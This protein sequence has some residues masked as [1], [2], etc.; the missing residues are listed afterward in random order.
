MTAP[1]TPE[2]PRRLPLNAFLLTEGHHE[3]AWRLPESDP[4]RGLDVG[5][6]IELAR[7]AER[8]K[9]D[10]IFF[11][12]GPALGKDPGRRPSAGFE[13]ITLLSAIAVATERIGLAGSHH[14]TDIARR[15]AEAAAG[16]EETA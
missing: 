13:P 9:L 6:F 4:L 8:G 12:D 14:R 11:A 3:A 2:Q 1:S 16:T 7:T 15:A 5:Y 10:S